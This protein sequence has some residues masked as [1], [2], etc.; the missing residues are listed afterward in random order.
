MSRFERLD[1]PWCP[2]RSLWPLELFIRFR[3]RRGA[4]FKMGSS[5]HMRW[6]AS[7]DGKRFDVRIGPDYKRHGKKV[8]PCLFWPIGLGSFRSRLLPICSWL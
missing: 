4:N 2:P 5:A 3:R 1:C 6:A 8:K 7:G